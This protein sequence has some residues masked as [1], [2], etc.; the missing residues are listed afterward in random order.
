[1][2]S[3]IDAHCRSWQPQPFFLIEEAMLCLKGKVQVFIPDQWA[4]METGD[5]AYILEGVTRLGEQCF[6]LVNS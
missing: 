1:M 6:N 4:D 3:Y 2:I 5:I